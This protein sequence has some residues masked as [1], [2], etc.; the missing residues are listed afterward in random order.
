[1]EVAATAYQRAVLGLSDVQGL[2]D[3][4][5]AAIMHSNIGMVKSRLSRARAKMRRSLCNAQEEQVQV[6]YT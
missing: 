1:L 3:K 6:S 2:S 4:E 5:S